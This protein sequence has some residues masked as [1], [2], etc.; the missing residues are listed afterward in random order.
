MIYK[1]LKILFLSLPLIAVSCSDIMVDEGDISLDNPESGTECT[2]SLRLSVSD[3]FEGDQH[4]SRSF[5]DNDVDENT[6]KDF[7]FIEY[8]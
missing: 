4:L 5:D 6:I 2:I 8:N 3:G 1:W 7:W